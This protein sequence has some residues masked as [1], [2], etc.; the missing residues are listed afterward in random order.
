MRSLSV[1]STSIF[2]LVIL[3]SLNAQWTAELEIPTEPSP[4]VDDWR[5]AGVLS[6]TLTSTEEGE[7]NIKFV[8]WIKR[9]ATTVLTGESEELSVTAPFS[10]VYESPEVVDW[11]NVSYE[12]SLESQIL[13]T[14][15][16]PEG[17]Y[18]LCIRCVDVNTG[19]TL[20]GD[21]A[22]FTVVWPSP[23][24]LIAPEDGD[25]VSETPEFDWDELI[26][27]AG[28]AI[29][30]K[31]VIAELEPGETESEAIASPDYEIT[32]DHP[33]LA[34]PGDAPE[35][36]AG[37]SYVW[38]IQALH[39]GEP[40]GQ[41]EGKSEIWQFVYQ[42]VPAFHVTGLKILLK[43]TIF[44]GEAV[45]YRVK[46][47]TAPPSEEGYVG[48]GTYRDGGYWQGW[49]LTLRDSAIFTGLPVP[50]D[51]ADTGSHILRVELTQPQD[52]SVEQPYFVKL[53]APRVVLPGSLVVIP[54][55]A[56]LTNI[57]YTDTTEVG[58]NKY[59]VSGTG[60]LH[61]LSLDSRKTI[62]DVH[63][64]ELVL[65]LS[66]V[67]PESSQ[68][69][70]GRIYRESETDS[71]FL[72]LYHG[73]LR[74]KKVEYIGDPTTPPNVL[75]ID[76]FISLPY[77]G[78]NL[79]DIENL[80]VGAEGIRGKRFDIEREFTLWGMTFH[81]D[82]V[83][84]GYGTPGGGE[85]K[86]YAG[87]T[88]KIKLCISGT[89][90]ELTDF[91]NLKVY[92]DGSWEGVI[93][94]ADPFQLIPG[95]N[96]VLLEKLSFVNPPGETDWYLQLEGEINLPE[97]FDTLE[98]QQFAFKVNADGSGIG[99]VRVFQGHDGLG[100]DT[101]EFDLWIVTIDPIYVGLR[102]K[103]DEGDLVTE[104]SD[105]SIVTDFYFPII[106]SDEKS[107]IRVGRIVREDSVIPGV[108]VTFDGDVLWSTEG[109][110]TLLRNDTLNLR[111][112]FWI[113]CSEVAIWPYPFAFVF[114]GS[115][116]LNFRVIE[117]SVGFSNL[118][119]TADGFENLG[120]AISGGSFAIMEILEVGVDN[121]DFSDTPPDIQY[122]KDVSPSDS[123]RREGRG[124]DSTVTLHVDWYFRIE[125][126]NINLLAGQVMS[127]DFDILFVYKSGG[128][129]KFMLKGVDLDIAGMTLLSD[130]EYRNPSVLFAGKLE[131]IP[132]TNIGATVVGRI[133]TKE[134]G[135]PTFGLFLAATGLNITIAGVVTLNDV[136]GGFFYNPYD[137]DIN[138]VWRMCGFT[139]NLRDEFDELSP[140]DTTGPG[141]FAFMLYAGAFIGQEM[142]IYGRALM[143]LT[144]NNWTLNAE[145]DGL[146]DLL[147]GAAY[148]GIGWTPQAWAEGMFELD[149]DIYY[150]ISGDACA[151]FYVYSTDAWAIM[152]EAEL[153]VLRIAD[154]DSE[155]FIGPPGFLL[156]ITF[157]AGFDAGVVAG[158]V[159]F[160]TMFWWK[161]NV[162]W[163]AYAMVDADLE[164]LWG[165]V[166]V[167]GALEGAFIGAPEFVI[168]CVGSFH[169]EICWVT[170][171]EGSI[172]ITVGEN[173]IDG[174]TGRNSRYDEIIEEARHVSDE[175]KEAKEQVQQ[176]MEDARSALAA[177]TNAQRERAGVALIEVMGAGG[178]RALL[179][180][181]LYYRDK[182]IGWGH[183][184]RGKYMTFEWLNNVYTRAI[185]GDA[186]QWV[187][188]QR[189]RL[190]TYEE[191]VQAD[192]EH[193]MSKLNAARE[194]WAEYRDIVTRE[195]PE[196]EDLSYYGNP[197]GNKIMR[198]VVINGRSRTIMVG[199]E[200]DSSKA[201]DMRSAVGELKES[202]DEYMEQLRELAAEYED[203]MEQ[204]DYILFGDSNAM[205]VAFA[206]TSY[207]YNRM[208]EYFDSYNKYLRG[209]CD[210]CN[211]IFV[212]I[213][214]NRD[215]IIND[216]HKQ[217]NF[218]HDMGLRDELRQLIHIRQAIILTLLAAS[219]PEA[220]DSVREQWART[221]NDSVS[222]NTIRDI[223]R[224]R[225]LA[226][227]LGREVWYKIPRV[228]FLT[229]RNNAC[230]MVY[231]LPDT[232]RIYRDEFES[233][234]G[235]LTRLADG[236]HRR[237]ARLY[238][239]LWDLY[240]QLGLNS[241]GLAIR[242]GM[243][244]TGMITR[245]R[246]GFA[247][248]PG[249]T[250]FH[251]RGRYVELYS[252]AGQYFAKRDSIA[253][254]LKVP[255]ITYFSGS[256]ESS[257]LRYG[258]LTLTVRATPPVRVVDYAWA[259]H[260]ADRPP[261][262][263]QFYSMA[264][265]SHNTGI[266][267]RMQG[268]I[269][270]E[271][272][273]NYVVYVRATGA[274]GYM[275]TRRG[276]IYIDYPRGAGWN[277][278]VKAT[279][280]FA[281]YTG[282]TTPVVYDQGDYTSGTGQLY[283]R[284]EAED[285]E[286]GI[287]EY[288]YWVGARHTRFSPFLRRYI[289]IWDSVV[290]WTSAGGR[291]EINIRGLNL[292]HGA[293]YYIRMKARNGAG[294]WSDVG[295]SD[296]ITVDTTPPPAPE[297]Y[298]AG[299]VFRGGITPMIRIMW[300][301]VEDDESPFDR[302]YYEFGDTYKLPTATS[303]STRVTY[304]MKDTTD[305]I[306]NKE[307]Y[308]ALRSANVLGLMSPPV[309][310]TLKFTD[311]TPPDF[312]GDP[313]ITYTGDVGYY[314][315]SWQVKDYESGIKS[316]GI[317]VYV[318]V[319]KRW[320]PI[321]KRTLAGDRTFAVFGPWQSGFTYMVKVTAYNYAGLERTEEITYIVP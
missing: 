274:G 143:T 180:A 191:Q 294:L 214:H 271:H 101:T 305:I 51:T 308:F 234:W 316:I 29:N 28:Y 159:E 256:W 321:S 111:D 97:P 123:A 246:G 286:S 57:R 317:T 186:A 78:G 215:S 48:G 220:A 131:G 238:E 240:D 109:V 90:Y 283:A 139:D 158:S 207:S 2:I 320:E 43:D 226:D 33:P 235:A 59:R 47:K 318:K 62:D 277:D 190:S 156:D 37:Q 157:D 303:R 252:P 229:F 5:T 95:N 287:E 301:H 116:G 8:T 273:G 140:T 224:L 201:M 237:K 151:Q 210:S 289:T 310:C 306:P 115:M 137:E 149:I 3:G 205:E 231:A 249:G 18:E 258:I 98:P 41:N 212:F 293:T 82:T 165:L 312:V 218:L 272:R 199:Y 127:G 177:L 113:N 233:E 222:V 313:K 175:M 58:T 147:H 68:I 114:T 166:G 36:E 11:P 248:T 130:F 66:V 211:K 88:G 49:G 34:Y 91:H 128:K 27:P 245:M 241:P 133:G 266:L 110:I 164:I 276:E 122:C 19:D 4:F 42:T 94:L 188:S 244:G 141:S 154:F 35:L 10:Q 23:P 69:K 71:A 7:F 264:L 136:G 181:I 9:E 307:Y 134:D 299:I 80:E 243:L 257:L 92:H 25:T 54:D 155:L 255:H 208:T 219:S 53:G 285:P 296:G 77:V 292:K 103:F 194:L 161:V 119:I 15:M 121:V 172:W 242:W 295:V 150:I 250:G 267:K 311:S 86:F 75:Y 239:L 13:R 268:G 118:E 297:I 282:P 38:Q 148:L 72:E 46:I 144:E 102:L 204:L 281:D 146:E 67:H 259:L 309:A 261:D 22:T 55:V 206:Q 302:Y 185:T 152:V 202:Y 61:L 198:T 16:L 85:R 225:D 64:D 254:K 168:Y 193:A 269:W 315:V 76:A 105:V 26:V 314:E 179:I 112:V 195:L 39:E 230:G 223:D 56:L 236:V 176:A 189:D 280:S 153:T 1:I 17:S 203:N 184:Y 275:A 263:L 288:F 290:G 84:V 52:T 50:S 228:G 170:V 232:M 138:V 31:F 196:L 135:A 279:V 278:T 253:E 182:S 63:I 265:G 163:G 129:K 262:T 284:W 160:D 79:F 319:D 74:V 291:T 14:G 304:F 60:K 45:P 173:G 132:G 120:T 227:T 125:G 213:V 81:I 108:K 217:A 30:Y 70:G 12:P 221:G 20:A 174:G 216:V 187:I 209:V 145:V 251:L 24:N 117:G 93:T 171:F 126:A 32:V 200:F 65:K 183:W 73:F 197:V 89:E 167:G 99:R 270:G 300:G 298:A 192:C 142:L 100:N 104:E 107:R 44:T 178:L 260:R 247:G 87:L 96:Y 83:S 169:A 124:R 40:I 106:N 6:L 21:C 162:S